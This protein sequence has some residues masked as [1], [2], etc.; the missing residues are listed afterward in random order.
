MSRCSQRLAFQILHHQEISAVLM[1][2][3][4]EGADVRMIQ[5]GNRSSFTLEPFSQFGTISKMRG[6][7]LMATIR[8]RRV[9]LAR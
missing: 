8:S 9:S 1:P 2:D 3:V 4:I 7:T 5:A 6:R